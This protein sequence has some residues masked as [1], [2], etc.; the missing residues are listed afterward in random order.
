MNQEDCELKLRGWIE[1]RGEVFFRDDLTRLFRDKPEVMPE[2]LLDC[3]GEFYLEWNGYSARD[4]MG[5][6]PGRRGGGRI[7]CNEK[8]VGIIIPDLP[9]L[10]VEE[11]ITESV[12]LRA[13]C[14]PPGEKA[15]VAFS[16]GVDSALIAKLAK[17][18]AVTVGL[19][20]SHDLKHAEEVAG[21]ADILDVE[22]VEIDK[23]E[24]RPALEKVLKVIPDKSPV[25]AS[26]AVT[27]YFVTR[28]AGEN[29]YDRVLAGQGAD[30]LF[31][32][33][34]RYL[35]TE[36]I[37]E[38]LNT[39]FKSLSRQGLRD[40]SVAGMNGT[41]LSCPFQDI[42]VVR[43][44]QSLP[45]ETLVAGGIRKY[46]LRV[47]ASAHMPNEAAFYAKKAMQYGSGIWK[48]IQR[49]ARQYGYKN[50]VQHY[51]EHLII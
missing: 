35:E 31:G 46:P 16:G 32:G 8:E 44:A 51:L 7:F 3:G 6:I 15:V 18:P 25:E 24:I 11:A 30:E 10:P 21:M 17:L 22:L 47:A 20:G 38:T 2:W 48:E 41:Y 33:Y 50:S 42:R 45:P 26:I 9:A 40:Q 4:Y 36:N 13:E 14:L 28:W 29:G 27:M 1:K 19:K 43:A 39:D 5:I 37:K 34:A 49:Q 12:R 23:N